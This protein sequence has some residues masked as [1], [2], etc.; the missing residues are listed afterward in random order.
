MQNERDNLQ[1]FPL[2]DNFS[3]F[4]CWVRVCE[5]LCCTWPMSQMEHAHTV[6]SWWA[7]SWEVRRWQRTAAATE[8]QM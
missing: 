6:L 1:E 5:T 7:A 8:L 3:P 2:T 4:S